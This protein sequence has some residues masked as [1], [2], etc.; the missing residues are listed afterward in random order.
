MVIDKEERVMFLEDCVLIDKEILI[1]TDFHIG[2]EEHIA[3]MGVLPDLQ[4]KEIIE[5]LDKVF[6]LLKKE[7]IGIKK[8]IILGDL[9]HEFG[10]ISDKEWRETIGLLDYLDERIVGDRGKKGRI[11]L[12][13]GNHD[14]IL[15]PI[16]KKRNI[17]LRDYYCL[18]GICFMH[19]NKLYP[20]C[21]E[22]GKILMFGHM[23]PSIT[24][25][26]KYK[27]E[28]FKCFLKGKWMKKEVYVLPSFSPISFGYDLKSFQYDS[29]KND[30]FFIVPEKKLKDF[31]VIIYN[32]ID[33]KEI[34]FG[35]LRKLL[36]KN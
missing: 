30:G 35:K 16:A 15:R 20:R 14:N 27:G 33:E 22:N 26:D 23:H 36:R 1:F 3:E 2:Y 6:D 12:I 18:N 29:E 11:I 34:N 32:P 21:F 31:E 5:R 24:L 28:K 19:G 13:K 10:G 25:S 17:E 4:F 7:K 8:I 9:K